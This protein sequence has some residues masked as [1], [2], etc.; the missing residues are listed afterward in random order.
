CGINT[1]NP[2]PTTSV[3]ELVDLHNRRRATTL[4][5]F[6]PETLLAVIISK[7]GEMWEPFLRDGFEPFLDR[8]L[9]R[10]IHSDQIVTLETTSQVVRISSITLDHGLLRT[11]P[12]QVDRS[13][14]EVFGGSI[15]G[16]TQHIDLQPDGNR[17]DLMKG[18][19][20]ARST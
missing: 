3:N 9:T 16:S 18:L 6:R 13:G 2:R 19:I 17:F 10:W 1:S 15:G 14:R 5:P 4:A 20:Y 11:V 12:V 7:F 8:Y